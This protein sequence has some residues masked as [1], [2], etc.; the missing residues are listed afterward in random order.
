MTF[1]YED[2]AKHY[3]VSRATFTRHLNKLIK[4][5]QFKKTAKGRY[6]N[7]SDAVKIAG[8]LGFKI[9]AIEDSIPGASQAPQKKITSHPIKSI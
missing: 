8:L 2:L 7:E 1:S 5:N 9:R 4:N 3:G 6:F